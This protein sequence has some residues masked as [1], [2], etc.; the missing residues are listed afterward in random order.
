MTYNGWTNY[1]TWCVNLWITNDEGLLNY[2][3]EIAREYTSIRELA[4]RLKDETAEENPLKNSLNSVYKDLLKSALDEVD[5]EEI[6]EHLL[7][8]AEESS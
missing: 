2:W 7:E 8:N 6:A 5:W 3:E 1:E 4:E